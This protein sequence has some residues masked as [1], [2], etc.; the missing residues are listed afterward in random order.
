MEEGGDGAGFFA[1][2]SDTDKLV[3]RCELKAAA[4]FD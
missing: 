1:S 4:C 3:M 2:E